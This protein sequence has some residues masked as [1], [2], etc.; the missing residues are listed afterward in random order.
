MYHLVY[1]DGIIITSSSSSVVTALLQDL[2]SDFALKDLGELN[3]FLGV[4]VTRSSD[5]LSLSQEWYA[6]E[7]LRRVGMHKC[8]PVQTTLATSKK[9][10]LHNGKALGDEEAA[11]YRGIVGGLQY[12]TLTQL[13]ISFVVNRIC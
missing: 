12:L 8:K 10:S 5:V 2:R 1:V 11:K 3:Y 9:L 7:V 4:Q 6:M 13:D